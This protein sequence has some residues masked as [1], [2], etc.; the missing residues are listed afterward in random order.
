[1]PELATRAGCSPM[2]LRCGEMNLS[3]PDDHQ[4]PGDHPFL[5]NAFNCSLVS[6]PAV[7]AA[8]P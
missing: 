1:M 3:E 6:P 5:R 7:K 8:I 4:A 2:K